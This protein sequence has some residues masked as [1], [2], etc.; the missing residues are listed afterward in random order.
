MYRTLP[1][2]LT[3]FQL[4]REFEFASLLSLQH[5]D[6]PHWSALADKIESRIMEIE[7]RQIRYPKEVK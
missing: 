6:N 5:P 2:D 3:L 7:S 4:R 1:C